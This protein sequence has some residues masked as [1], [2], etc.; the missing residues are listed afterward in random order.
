MQWGVSLHDGRQCSRAVAGMAG[1]CIEGEGCCCREQGVLLAALRACLSLCAALALRGS[2][3]TLHPIL[4]VCCDKIKCIFGRAVAN[5][6]HSVQRCCG[7][8]AVLSE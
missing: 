4:L 6:N 1:V 5:L 2:H 3:P 8:A 7:A